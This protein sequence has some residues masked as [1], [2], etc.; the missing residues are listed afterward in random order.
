[1]LCTGLSEANKTWSLFFAV[2]HLTRDRACLPALLISQSVG[3]EIKT[4][5]MMY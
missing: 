3:P 2:S 5:D 1:L 4:F